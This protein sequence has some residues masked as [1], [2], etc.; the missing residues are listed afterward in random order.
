MYR[1]QVHLFQQR[2]ASCQNCFDDKIKLDTASHGWC[3]RTVTG[4]SAKLIDNIIGLEFVIERKVNI[5][6][7]EYYA[8]ESL[9]RSLILFVIVQ[10]L[11]DIHQSLPHQSQ[12]PT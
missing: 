7:V 6:H 4:E 2:M 12:S 3:T 1:G 9:R 8:C 5:V 11:L 10:L